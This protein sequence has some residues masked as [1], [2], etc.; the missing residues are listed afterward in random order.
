MQFVFLKSW[1][2][3]GCS[4]LGFVNRSSEIKDPNNTNNKKYGTSEYLKA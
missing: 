3:L 2:K 4:Y 1:D